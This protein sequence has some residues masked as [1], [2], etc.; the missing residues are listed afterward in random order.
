[1][2]LQAE[3]NAEVESSFKYG[4]SYCGLGGRPL[5]QVAFVRTLAR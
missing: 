2:Y 3:R 1:M 5:G 4:G